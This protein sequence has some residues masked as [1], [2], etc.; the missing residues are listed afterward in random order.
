MKALIAGIV[1]VSGLVLTVPPGQGTLFTL[2]GVGAAHAEED[3]KKE[4]EAIC[5]KTDE[6]M[7]ASKEELQGL[8]ARC[9]ALKAV[10]EK[11]DGSTRKVYMR[12]LQSC[13]DLLAF[14]LASK[15][16]D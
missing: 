1:L 13:R 16:K 10:I 15:E 8:V 3:W 7:N 6:A 4:F 11:L 9:D 12:R 5:S 14:V 2:Y